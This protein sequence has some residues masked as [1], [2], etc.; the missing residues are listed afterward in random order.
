MLQESSIKVFRL[1]LGNRWIIAHLIC[2]WLLSTQMEQAFSM[3]QKSRQKWE[4]L[5]MGQEI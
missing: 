5:T 4:L 1:G 2:L 3:N